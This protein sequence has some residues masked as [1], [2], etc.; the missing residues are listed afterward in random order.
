MQT[1]ITIISGLDENHLKKP[2]G[3]FGACIK[4]HCLTTCIHPEQHIL[5]NHT[6]GPEGNNYTYVCTSVNSNMDD[7]FPG[8]VPSCHVVLASL[9]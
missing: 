8:S 2:N 1:M 9:F 4:Q 3:C 5:A 6:D 7:L